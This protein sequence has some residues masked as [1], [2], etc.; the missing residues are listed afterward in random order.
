MAREP[1]ASRVSQAQPLPKT[2]AP[3]LLKAVSKAEREPN[4][5]SMSL[6]SSAFGAVPPDFERMGHQKVWL[7]SPPALVADRGA[8]GVGDG[9]KV[10]D[11]LLGGF[12]GEVGVAGDGGVEVVDVGGVV[13]VVVE[14]HGLGVNVG[15]EGVIGVGEWGEGEGAGGGG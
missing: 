1:L 12:N 10:G 9:A 3:A 7:A 6:A 14:V 2:L 5:A 13:L 11:E 8:D 15:L 4:L